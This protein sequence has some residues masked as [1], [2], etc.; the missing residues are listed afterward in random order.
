MIRTL[1]PKRNALVMCRKARDCTEEIKSVMRGKLM[2]DEKSAE[3]K[4]RLADEVIDKM[5]NFFGQAIGNADGD[6]Q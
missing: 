6:K 3:G 1:S 4:G 2:A 5:Q